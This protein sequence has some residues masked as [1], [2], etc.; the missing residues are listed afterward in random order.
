MGND[1]VIELDSITEFCKG[2]KMTE[3]AKEKMVSWQLVTASHKLTSQL[4]AVQAMNIL[5]RQDVSNRYKASGAQGRRFFTTGK[6]LALAVCVYDKEAASDECR[7]CR[8]RSRWGSCLQRLHAVSLQSPSF[9][10]IK[11][12]LAGRSVSLTQAYP[13]SR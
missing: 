8:P 11:A 2:N 10:E 13:L 12:N 6:L 7:G 3:A 5:F 1:H 9:R 4:V